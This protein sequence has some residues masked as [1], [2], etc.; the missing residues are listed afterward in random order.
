MRPSIWS[1]PCAHTYKCFVRPHRHTKRMKKRREFSKA[2]TWKICVSSRCFSVAYSASFSSS[3][4]I[5]AYTTGYHIRT[6]TQPCRCWPTVWTY[7]SK[8]SLEISG[9]YH[10]R[11]KTQIRLE[12][13]IRFFT[14]IFYILT[15]LTFYYNLSLKYCN[16]EKVEC[17]WRF[18]CL[19]E[20]SIDLLSHYHIIIHLFFQPFVLQDRSKAS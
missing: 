7:L 18:K 3:L 20:S 5:Q 6:Y 2:D 8:A 14:S 1:L 12:K 15:C 4:Y 11:L 9:T 19:H 13:P 17:Y 10:L 16:S